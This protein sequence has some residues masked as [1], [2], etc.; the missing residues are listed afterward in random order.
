MFSRY[1][2]MTDDS[3]VQKNQKLKSMQTKLTLSNAYYRNFKEGRK[4]IRNYYKANHAFKGSN[5]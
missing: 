5:T 3:A 4:P 2:F 1:F